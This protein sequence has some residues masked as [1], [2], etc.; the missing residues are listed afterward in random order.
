[1][2]V[3]EEPGIQEAGS[4]LTEITRLREF[5][6][7]GIAVDKDTL[8]SCIREAA[9]SAHARSFRRG[10][11]NTKTRSRMDAHASVNMDAQRASRGA[12][13]APWCRPRA[14]YDMRPGHRDRGF[15]FAPVVSPLLSSFPSLL[16][17]TF[18]CCD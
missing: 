10:E 9:S 16:L 4:G 3:V 7:G 1:M 2:S 14:A 13:A 18:C 11:P 5:V 6:R 17:F 8:P 12:N 15:F